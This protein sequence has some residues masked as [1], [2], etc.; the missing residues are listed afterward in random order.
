MRFAK[1]DHVV[2]T[3]ADRA[4]V[5]SSA[6]TFG[7]PTG[8]TGP[9]VP[10]AE[11]ISPRQNMMPNGRLRCAGAFAAEC[12]DPAMFARIGPGMFKSFVTLRTGN[13][14]VHALGYRTVAPHVVGTPLIVKALG[15]R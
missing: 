10:E 13:A 2:E 11:V 15:I 8:P 9:F 14:W 3:F 5:R 4:D 7:L 6:E 1:H 12:D